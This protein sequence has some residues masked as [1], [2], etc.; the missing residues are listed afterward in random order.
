MFDSCYTWVVSVSAA[1]ILCTYTNV[2]ILGIYT[3]VQSLDFIKVIVGYGL[4][5][6]G[7][8]ITSLVE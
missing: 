1:Y 3:I 7:V 2:P 5:K 4:I 8:W 6:K